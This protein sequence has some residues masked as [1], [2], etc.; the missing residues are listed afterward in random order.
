MT[1]CKT[2][3][4]PFDVVIKN[5]KA[6]MTSVDWATQLVDEWQVERRKRVTH[7][8]LRSHQQKKTVILKN[9]SLKDSKTDISFVVIKTLCEFRSLNH[10]S[11]LHYY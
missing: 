11:L 4:K 1:I 6:N 5:R 8:W 3:V 9:S 7:N 2:R 10:H